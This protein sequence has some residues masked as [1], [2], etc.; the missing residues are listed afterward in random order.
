MNNTNTQSRRIAPSI[1]AA[2]AILGAS[3]VLVLSAGSSSK[4]DATGG[5]S[6]ATANVAAQSGSVKQRNLYVAMN[7]LWS[8]HMAWTYAV[9]NDFATGSPSLNASIDRLLQ[10]Q[11]DIGNAVRPYYGKA[12]ADQL[13][14]LLTEHIQLAVPVL[15]AAKAGDT[16]AL[17]TAVANWQANAKQIGTFLAKANPAW[18]GA[19][20]LLKAHITGTIAYATDAIKGDH[21]KAV[22]DYDKAEKHMLML[23]NVLSAG[24]IKQFPARFR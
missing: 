24:L 19:P 5:H 11:K 21:A 17:N 15:Q 20:N 6:H 22:A 23:G 10:N 3:I 2:L 8:Q 4:A 9:V 7:T 18:K 14:K 13:T 12:A 1:A 16:V